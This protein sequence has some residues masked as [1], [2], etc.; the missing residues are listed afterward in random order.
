MELQDADAQTLISL[1]HIRRVMEETGK[2][3]KVVSEMLDL[4]NRDLAEVTKAD[5]FIVSDKLISLLMSQV[6]E[7]KYLMRVFEDLFDA[8][9]SE[10]YLKPM[11]DYIKSGELI[12]FYTVIE[13]AKR[14]GETA[15]G[16]RIASDAHDNSKAYGV[17]VNPGKSKMMTFKEN[18]KLIV[19]AEN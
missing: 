18:D 1:L 9:G 4:R 15:I 12:N 11:S 16:Y 19:L 3:V 8:D 2:D 13:S 5:D 14:K 17:V 7:N 10:I 6:S